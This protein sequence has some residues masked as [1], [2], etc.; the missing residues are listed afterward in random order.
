MDAS[1]CGECS[2]CIAWEL[3][4][5]SNVEKILWQMS[6]G[7]V[8]SYMNLMGSWMDLLIERGIPS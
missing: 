2:H 4:Y 3:S 7:D 6:E 8:T 5:L 1:R